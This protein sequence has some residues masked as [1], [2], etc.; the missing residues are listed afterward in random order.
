LG[1]PGPSD[2][3]GSYRLVGRCPSTSY[4]ITCSAEGYKEST[5]EVITD[6]NGNAQQDFSLEPDCQ[7]TISGRV[8]D[9]K[10]NN[11]PI[12]DA[13][14]LICQN[15]KCMDPVVTDSKGQ[16]SLKGFCPSSNFDITCSAEGFRNQEK[17]GTTDSEGNSKNQDIL[18]E[19]E[20]TLK[21]IRFEGTFYRG[22]APMGFT[23][24]Y[25]KVDKIIEG[26]AIPIGD[27]IGVSVYDSSVL[28]GQGGSADTLQDGDRAEVYARI[29]VDKGKHDDGYE[30][31]W[32]ASITEDGKYYVRKASSGTSG[33]SGAILVEVYD[34]KTEAPIKEPNLQITQPKYLL[35]NPTIV[36]GHFSADGSCPLALTTL[37]C[38]AEN[39]MPS[40]K[41]ITTDSKGD[42]Q[43]IFKL[44]PKIRA[45]WV[46][47]VNPNYSD[48]INFAKSNKINLIFQSVSAATDDTLL[49]YDSL[50]NLAHQNNIQI[51]AM[52]LADARCALKE[53]R[54]ASLEVV[55]KV[56]KYKFDGIHLDTEPHQQ[57]KENGVVVYEGWDGADVEFI[58]DTWK[59]FVSLINDVY[60][61]THGKTTF[62]ASIPPWY[63]VNA[64]SKKLKLAGVNVKDLYGKADILVLMAYG[65]ENAEEKYY[66][67]PEKIKNSISNIMDDNSE[68]KPSIIIGIG[69]YEFNNI[70]N[71]EDCMIKLND[72]Y[73]GNRK[74]SGFSIFDYK[75]Y[76][77]LN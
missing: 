61:V 2:S 65:D 60:S 5:L 72:I 36:P 66:D 54:I 18:M 28:P 64:K 23:V 37:T 58:Q 69:A 21:D 34:A 53:N 16:Y 42:G 6:K 32:S 25:F 50:I 55:K 11:Q 3:S 43:A 47:E 31:A 56:L 41:L 76:K 22:N 12:R 9:V 70:N 15:G 35:V 39:Y 4:E 73:S 63:F 1:A 68:N 17:T 62:S 74:F 29:Y 30:T 40:A 8:S 77:E 67:T 46:S 27:P 20:S 26:E 38:K 24:Y 75:S 59:D 51:H 49:Q 52:I 33:C 19:S 10:N 45:M 14:L 13:N 71:I 57:V 48:L 7:G 44:E